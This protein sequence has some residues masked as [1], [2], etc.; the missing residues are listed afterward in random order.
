MA[1]TAGHTGRRVLR[2]IDYELRQVWEVEPRQQAERGI[3]NKVGDLLWREK[4]GWA[5]CLEEAPSKAGQAVKVRLRGKE[6]AVM[7]GYYVNVSDLAG[8]RTLAA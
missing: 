7:N 3:T 2:E 4:I 1:G 5:I 8:M 6:K